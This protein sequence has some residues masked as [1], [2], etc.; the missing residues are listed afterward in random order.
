MD[1]LNG[2]TKRTETMVMTNENTHLFVR[3]RIHR[4]PVLGCRRGDVVMSSLIAEHGVIINLRNVES[5]MVRN[6]KINKPQ[7]QFVDETKV[8]E[9]F[10]EKG[11]FYLSLKM[12][13]GVTYNYFDADMQT[14]E[15]AKEMARELLE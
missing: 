1:G 11:R 6:R 15:Y 2:M 4:G 5:I 12:L 10:R 9:F 7:S 14:E 13:S 3:Y 8:E